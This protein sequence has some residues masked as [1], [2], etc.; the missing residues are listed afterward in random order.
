MPIFSRRVEGILHRMVYDL[1]DTRFALLGLLPRSAKD[2][3]PP[4]TLPSAFSAAIER[5]NLGFR[6]AGGRRCDAFWVVVVPGE[7][8]VRHYGAGVRTPWLFAPCLPAL[9]LSASCT[10]AWSM[11]AACRAT[12]AAAPGRRAGC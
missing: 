2:A 10:Y 11:A 8:E 7:A 9:Q 4:Y 1:R 3:A 6:W 12:P 5:V